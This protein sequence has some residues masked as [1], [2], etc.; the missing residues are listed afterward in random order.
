MHPYR[1]TVILAFLIADD[2]HIPHFFC[3]PVPYL[4]SNLLTP[5]VQLDPHSGG[6]KC[7]EDLRG[8]RKLVISDRQNGGLYRSEPKREMTREM[9]SENA[10]ESLKRTEDRSVY[11]YGTFA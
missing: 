3:F 1:H 11:R 5:I 7:L 2:Q 10:N 9:F 4:V 6:F 8:I